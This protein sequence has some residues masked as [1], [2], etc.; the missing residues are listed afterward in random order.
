MSITQPVA[1]DEVPTPECPIRELGWSSTAPITSMVKQFSFT[2]FPHHNGQSILHRMGTGKAM[3][4][5]RLSPSTAHLGSK[6]KQAK[7]KKKK[8]IG[9]PL[10]GDDNSPSCP[11]YPTI[12][13]RFQ[14]TS[15]GTAATCSSYYSSSS[16]HPNCQPPCSPP[17]PHPLVPVSTT[18]TNTQAITPVVVQPTTSITLTSPL[19]APVN[20]NN[21]SVMPTMPVGMFMGDSMLPLPDSVVAKICKLEFVD[22]SEL[23]PESWLLDE[24]ADEKSVAA[25]FKSKKKPVTDI[26]IWVQCVASYVAVFAQSFPA[27]T[28][29]F[30]AYLATT[31]RCHHRFEGLSWVFYDTAYRRRAAN[32]KTSTGLS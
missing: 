23:R 21:L 32:R 2:E 29:Q 7:K 11:L 24:E 16:T 30:M 1:P 14:P 31:V 8:P 18:S 4:V 20:S 15:H 3:A 27:H 25:L 22:M 13:N 5:A 12:H 26:L 6:N 19:P 10:N 28:P 9:F 17:P